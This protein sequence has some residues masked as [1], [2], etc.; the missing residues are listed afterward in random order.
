MKLVAAENGY[1]AWLSKVSAPAVTRGRAAV[2]GGPAGMAAAYFLRKA[3]WTLRSL[4]NRKHWA[5][6]RNIIQDSVSQTKPLIGMQRS[7]ETMSVKMVFNTEV[8]DVNELKAQGFENVVL[9][10][11]AFEPGT[12]NLEAETMNALEL[13]RSSRRWTEMSISE[14]TSL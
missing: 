13:L 9:A 12:L 2:S 11:R 14:R 5:A 1:E 4:R 10:S 6:L 8:A 7:S 3:A